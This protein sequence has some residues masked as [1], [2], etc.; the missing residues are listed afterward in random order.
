MKEGLKIYTVEFIPI[1]PVP[2]CLILA[3]GSQN[4]AEQMAKEKIKHTDVFTVKEVIIE[5][6]RIIKYLSGDY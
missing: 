3:A 4:E 6:P 1:W 2:S 5:Q